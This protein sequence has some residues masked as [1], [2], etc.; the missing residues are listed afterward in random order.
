MLGPI[1]AAAHGVVDGQTLHAEALKHRRMSGWS[2]KLM[3]ALPL[4]WRSL[5]A[6]SSY[7]LHSKGTP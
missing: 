2:L 6:I 7:W 5:V 1:G 3:M 4:S